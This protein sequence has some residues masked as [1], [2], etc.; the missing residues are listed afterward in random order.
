MSNDEHDSHGQHNHGSHRESNDH[1]GAHD[2]H[3]HHH[4][5]SSLTVAVLT[6][7]STR[8]VDSDESGKIAREILEGAG[9]NVTEYDT[10]PDEED[11]IRQR[12]M[13]VSTDVTVTA[14]GTGLTP[15]DVTV[16]A[17]RPLFGKE[18]PGFGE[19]F[20][21]LSHEDVGTPAMLSRA[22]AG[23]VDEMVVYALPG[24]KGAV[25]LGVEHAILPEMG[26]AVALA[27]RE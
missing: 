24:S 11:A 6:V 7:T 15:D 26:H 1:H 25:E 22:T 2:H 21:R 16:E 14:G 3:G 13:E 17:L 27:Q 9:H 12:V 5:T 19:Y 10:V 4:E 23:V 18:I 8:D 20:R